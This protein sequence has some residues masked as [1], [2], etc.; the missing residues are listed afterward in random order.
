MAHHP[1][2]DKTA[3]MVFVS[4]ISNELLEDKL[5]ELLGKI[6]AVLSFKIIYDKETGKS[7]GCAVCEYKDQ[8]T[9][10]NA[11]KTLNNFEIGGRLLKVDHALNEK[12]RLEIISVMQNTRN[13]DQSMSEKTPETISKA[14]SSLP[15]E[16]MFELLKQMKQCVQNNSTEAKN[17]LLQ[18]PQL[19]YALLQALVVMRIVDPQIAF[20]ALSNSNS[21]MT[22]TASNL[23][24]NLNSDSSISASNM[25]NRVSSSTTVAPVESKVPMKTTV[26]NSV[27]FMSAPKTPVPPPAPSIPFT[28]VA[29]PAPTVHDV[30]LRIVN[31]SPSNRTEQDKL[32][33]VTAG[34][35]L[36]KRDPRLQIQD[37]QPV[38]GPRTTSVSN[39]PVVPV[40]TAVS[41]VRVT[42]TSVT[43]S[44]TPVN[45]STKSTTSSNTPDNEKAALIMQVLRL[46]DAQIAMLPPEQ[47]QSIMLLKEQIAKST[48]R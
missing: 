42:S 48:K 9:A 20:T 13:N 39:A 29:P 46:T 45:S 35:E 47:R 31:A 4:G 6:G 17:M 5:K 41:S 16:Q 8:E 3:R 21:A 25:I 18:N 19:A 43:A 34:S 44:S 24:A 32:K 2:I 33:L 27:S 36:L 30:D 15:P 38:S 26:S 23:I 22:V 37:S 11:V 12:S 28:T 7:R 10:L 14:V 1:I 40:T